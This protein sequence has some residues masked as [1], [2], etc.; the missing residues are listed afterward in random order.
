[1]GGR[2]V[3]KKYVRMYA[4]PLIGCRQEVRWQEICQDIC[5]ALTRPDGKYSGLAGLPFQASARCDSWPLT[6]RKPRE[7][8]G[9]RDHQPDQLNENLLQIWLTA[10]AMVLFS[11]SGLTPEG[12]TEF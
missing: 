10:V 4:L 9:Q 2:Y 5:L 11:N 12:S 8:H 1:M 3:D 6:Y 7:R